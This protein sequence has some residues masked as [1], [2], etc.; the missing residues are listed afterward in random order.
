MGRMT[1]I[2]ERVDESVRCD[3]RGSGPRMKYLF[4]RLLSENI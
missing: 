2:E 1:D 3:T 4:N